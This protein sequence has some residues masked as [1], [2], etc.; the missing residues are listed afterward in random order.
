[1]ISQ[2]NQLGA[3]DLGSRKITFLLCEAVQQQFRLIGHAQIPSV[4]IQK[5]RIED[6]KKLTKALQRFC[7]ELSH[8]FGTLP[9]TVCLSQS[10]SHLQG[11]SYEMMLPLPGFRHCITQQNLEQLRQLAEKK[12]LPEDTV[13]IHTCHQF[14]TINGTREEHPVGHSANQITAHYQMLFGKTQPIRDQLYAVNQFGF[15]VKYL[16]FSGIA[17]ALATTTSVERENGVCVIDIGAQMTDFVVY[18]H[19]TPVVMG[20]LP[21]GGKNF[22]YDLC[23]GLRISETDAER[24][25][26]EHGIPELENPENS[27]EIWVVGDRSIG[28]KRVKRKHLHT[29]LYARAQE[30]FDYI[31]KCIGEEE[32]G[33]LLLAGVV[34]TGGGS[35]LKG[36][37]KV[38]A[39]SFHCDTCVRGAIATVDTA[40]KSPSYATSVG[41]L[42]YAL[43]STKN[44]PVF[45]SFWQRFASWFGKEV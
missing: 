20:T 31:V 43:Q 30:L 8:R 34:L 23:S 29:I 18:Q 37:E 3:F 19:N 22:T 41:L 27:A 21:V 38:A 10:G 24:L 25:K 12:E 5:G 14:Y 6:A 13:S 9:H 44:A 33:C 15:R 4:G 35:L 36:I 32:I 2:R 1:M 26:C 40:L 28:D 7:T 17:S 16:V 45:L 39:A 42:Q 11:M